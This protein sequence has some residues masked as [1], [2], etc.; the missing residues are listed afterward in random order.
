[1]RLE[2]ERG[3]LRSSLKCGENGVTL[4]Y[5]LME[6]RYSRREEDELPPRPVLVLAMV[7][8]REGMSWL[9]RF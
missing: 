6:F 8:T 3:E 5:L 2:V 1:M 4:L 9:S 7:E